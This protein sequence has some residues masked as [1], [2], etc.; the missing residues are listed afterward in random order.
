[1]YVYIRMFMYIYIHTH[2]HKEFS[3]KV[4]RRKFVYMYAMSRKNQNKLLIFEL[5]FIVFLQS[6]N[7]Y[8]NSCT[9]SV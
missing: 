7:I 1:M 4:H 3:R 2:T 9:G 6:S 8:K 5:V